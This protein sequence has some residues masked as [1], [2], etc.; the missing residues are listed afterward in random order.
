MPKQKPR[1]NNKLTQL[2]NKDSLITTLI[3][4]HNFPTLPSI[5][6]GTIKTKNII[7]RHN[8]KSVGEKILAALTQT[9]I[10]LIV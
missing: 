8:S 2:W 4:E 3:A 9:T 7:F 5:Q 6:N 10:L 1:L